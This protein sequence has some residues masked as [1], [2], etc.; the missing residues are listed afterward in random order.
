[1]G[2]IKASALAEPGFK[3][4]PYPFY[5]RM[6]AESPVFPVSIPFFGRGWLV[7]RYE[8]VV[9]VAKDDRFSRDILPKVR[10]LPGFV[11]VPL[12]R[13]MLSQDPRITPA[14]GSW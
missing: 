5:A 11:V 8:D 12:T 4:N 13:H 3:A 2:V 6:R 14:C 10:W 9:T 7:T 1:M